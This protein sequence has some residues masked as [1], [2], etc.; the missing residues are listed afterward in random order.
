[1]TPRFTWHGFQYCEI[2]SDGVTN[3][4]EI[5]VTGLTL[6][7]ALDKTGSVE[8]SGGNDGVDELLRK[9][10]DLTVRG[11]NSNN[12]GYMP[13]DCPTREKHGW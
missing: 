12:A 7:N 9:I 5:E 3:F 8:F 13:T 4:D 1:M 2:T 10:Q 6:N 11:Y